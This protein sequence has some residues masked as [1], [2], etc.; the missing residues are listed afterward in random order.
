MEFM[1]VLKS[2]Y[3]CKKFDGQ[4]IKDEQLDAI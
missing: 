1:E 3:S 2:L 4:R